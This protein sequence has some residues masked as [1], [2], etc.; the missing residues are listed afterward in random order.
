MG[1]DK[2]TLLRKFH[3]ARWDEDI[4]LEMS[5][6]GER[7]VL[8]PQAERG[9]QAE[10]GDGVSVIPESLRRKKPPEL[11][12]VNQAR[13]LRHYLHLSQETMGTDV[14][15]D[16]SEGTCT[17]KYNAE[18]PRALVRQKPGLDRNP[19]SSGRRHDPGHPGDVLQI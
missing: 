18:S 1:R 2:N 16:I 4:I 3:Q 5:V 6:P 11:P 13:V 17:M 8:L 10:V 14:T 7:G 9:I 19:S 12:E 15:I